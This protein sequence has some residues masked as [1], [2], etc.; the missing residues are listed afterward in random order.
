M[1]IS[2]EPQQDS[3]GLAYWRGGGLSLVEVVIVMSRE[4]QGWV[5]QCEGIWCNIMCYW[6][7]HIFHSPPLQTAPVAPHFKPFVAVPP[8]FSFILVHYIPRQRDPL[9]DA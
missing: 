3:S 2:L 9:G 6:S 7:T 5:A 1:A 4:M 8:A